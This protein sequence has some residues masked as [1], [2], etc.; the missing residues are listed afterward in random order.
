MSKKRSIATRWFV[1]SFSITVII[2]LIV[3]VGIYTTAKSY[4][5]NAVNQ[6]LNSEANIIAEV[7]TR[8]Y[9]D[10]PTNYADEVR[11][12]VEYF[13]KKNVMELMAIDKEGNIRISSS[14]FSPE[15]ETEMPDYNDA[16]NGESGTGSYVGKLNRSSVS[17]KYMAVTVKIKSGN[18][19]YSAVRVMTSLEKIDSQLMRMLAAAFGVSLFVLLL[20]FFMGIYFITS[21]L[22]PIKAMSRSAKKLAKGDFSGRIPILRNDE[23]GD[24]CETFNNMADELANSE[25]IKNDFIS[26]VSHELR[27]PLTAIKGWSETIMEM[28]DGETL[29]K[30]MRVIITETERLSSMVEELLDFSR[31]QNKRLL[32]QKANTDIIAEL[33]DAVLVYTERANKNGIKINYH[34][35]DD[36]AMIF[37]DKNRL[38][39]VFLNIL[40][41]AIKYIGNEGI[42][43]VEANLKSDSI[44]IKITDNG[45]G[46]SKEDL[47]KVKNRF[48]KA[49]NTIRGSGIGL[50][51]AD[52][53]VSLHGG[54][55]EIE[56]EL[57]KGTSVSIVLPTISKK[58]DVII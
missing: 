2:M 13:K 20:V 3:T 49:N 52:E 51:V 4:Y 14:G 45:C 53:L 10:S 47:P 57:G 37:G 18:S 28:K 17:E 32:L 38:R 21:I 55:L 7:L 11:D 29:V 48:Y 46:I 36:V 5:Y 54:R 26:S 19:D 27:T 23:I 15:N 8:F 42:I 22:S 35:P 41:N 30:G 50:S 39:Q 40:D 24:L 58:E 33:A 43:T 56:S 34:E 9:E 31:I 12:T 1:N 16:M 6:Y 44:E 25:K